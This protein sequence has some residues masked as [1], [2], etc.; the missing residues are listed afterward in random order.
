MV[1]ATRTNLKI[2]TP[3]EGETVIWRGPRLTTS[4]TI[5]LNWLGRASAGGTAKAYQLTYPSANEVTLAINATTGTG[6]TLTASSALFQAGHVGSYWEI[7]HRRDAAYSVITAA[8]TTIS[9]ASSTAIR[10]AGGWEVFSY[11]IWAATLFL[12]KKVGA[13]WEV[14]RSW[15]SN[16]DRNIIASGTEDNEVEMRLRISAGTSEASSTAAV[17]R[18]VL[19][20]VD[21]RVYGLVKVTAVGSL[22]ADGKATTATVDVLTTV[23]STAATPI[24]TEGA[25][26]DVRGYPRAVALHGQRLWF[27]GTRAEPQGIWGSVVNDYENFRRSTLDDASLKFTPAAQQANPIQWLGSH[28][29]LVIGTAGDEWTAGADG[30]GI[31]TPTNINVRRRSGYGSNHL[32]ALIFGDVILFLQ[33][34]G[35]RLRQVNP[36][37]ET[38]IW[39]ATDITVLAEHVT[40]AGIVQFAAMNH[41]VS[42]LWAVTGDGKLIG[43]TYEAEQNVFGWHVHETDGFIESVAVVY[44]A[45]SDEVWLAVKRGARRNIERLDPAVFSRDFAER[46]RLIYADAAVRLESETP[47][48]TVSGLDHL[49]GRTVVV[50]GDGAQ[51]ADATVIDGTVTLEREASTVVVGLAYSSLLQPTRREI[52]LRDGTSIGRKFRASRA[53]LQLHDS[54]GGEVADSEDSTFDAIRYR[55]VADPLDAPPPLFTGEVEAAVESSARGGVDVTVRQTQPFPLNVGAIVWKGDVYGE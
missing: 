22:N 9:A 17:P 38:T 49:N 20:A 37:S 41:P 43:M 55:T 45:E 53:L 3:I 40:Q 47:V 10:V 27:G 15:T 2:L 34:G 18:F 51:F 23:H 6:R 46:E 54:L 13:G 30:E 24:W 35:Q 33:R 42:I 52:P 19:E 31:I 8:V 36:R 7:V 25:W 14:V 12:E 11:G 1:G 32:P 29:N 26:S 50:L 44:G 39:S 4:T 5:L 28:G 21:S 16:K 48:A